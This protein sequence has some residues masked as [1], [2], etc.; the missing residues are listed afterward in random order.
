VAC[1][2]VTM[3]AVATA[4]EIPLRAGRI[5]AEGDIDFRGTL[6]VDKTA[7]VGFRAIRLVVELDTDAAQEK[8]EKLVQLTER[9]CIVFQ[10]LAG[11]PQLSMT[12]ARS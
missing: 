3:R 4:M 6:G 7:P 9:Y 1:A 5:R 11:Q 8:L 2:G 10:T 12:V